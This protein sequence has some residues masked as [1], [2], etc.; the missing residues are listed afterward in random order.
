MN[1]KKKQYKH[2]VSS[3]PHIIIFEYD[4]TKVVGR[5]A[6]SNYRCHARLSMQTLRYIWLLFTFY[7]RHRKY[8]QQT[9][10]YFV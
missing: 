2:I 5:E 10:L 1:K 6:C 4:V 8:I 3:H 9:R 7:G